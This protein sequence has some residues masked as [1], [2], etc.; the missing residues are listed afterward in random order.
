ECDDG[1]DLGVDG[2][3]NYD[4]LTPPVPEYGETLTYCTNSC[5][6]ET[7]SS[8][9]GDGSVNPTYEQCDKEQFGQS[10]CG[11]FGL[12]F[13]EGVEKNCNSECM[14]TN[15]QDVDFW[16][17]L[18][19]EWVIENNK[20]KSL[21]DGK[22]ISDPFDMLIG[23]DYTLSAKVEDLA[24][25]SKV[26]IKLSSECYSSDGTVKDCGISA[27][28]LEFTA[29]DQKSQTIRL[30]TNLNSMNDGA[31]FRGLKLLIET[32]GSAKISEISLKD[33]PAPDVHFDYPLPETS[34]TGCCPSTY[35][36]D[37]E[38]CVDSG[39]WMNNASYPPLWNNID[40]FSFVDN[41]TF[42]ENRSRATGYRCVLD[43]SGTAIWEP[44]YIKYDW[45]F[46]ESGYCS[47]VTDCFVGYDDLEFDH[48]Y[49][50]RGCIPDGEIISDDFV[51]KTGNHYCYKGNW[52]TKSYMIALLLQDIAKGDASGDERYTLSCYDDLDMDL[53]TKID[54]T[55][56]TLSFIQGTSFNTLPGEG[57]DVVSAC[58]MTKPQD[59]DDQIIA[60]IVLEESD[61]S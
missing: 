30:S 43:G 14:F 40:V 27:Q 37:G 48:Q 32:T 7:I 24:S 45:E 57:I 47:N 25:E 59:V 20:I 49:A 17:V 56:T 61:A 55:T 41:H 50:S 13:V 18:E 28:A 44:A 10:T 23:K 22:V 2:K 19:K 6:L 39:L 16:N 42:E 34:L 33:S 46:K 36:W 52:T 51:E 21:T 5:K 29:N 4:P 58:I 1:S 11:D 38:V 9:C 15:C 26:T 60:G 53:P 31:Y 12:F 35:C 54:P 8:V 3:I